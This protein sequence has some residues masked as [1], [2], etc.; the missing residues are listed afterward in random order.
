MKQLLIGVMAL[1]LLAVPL[2]STARDEEND[3]N[4]TELGEVVVT[5]TRTETPLGKVG[6]S[7][8]SVVT[9]EDIEA[10]KQSTV[11][12]VLRAVPGLDV[13]S[14]GGP[15]TQTAISLR[16]A[17]SKNTLILIDGI[18]VNDPS[19][20]NRGANLANITVDNI[21][22]VEVVRGPQ[23]VLYGSNA[24]AG[25]VNI[26]TKK[27]RGKPAVA[28]SIEGGSYGTWKFTADAYGEL[29]EKLNFSLSA[30]R[31]DSDGF[32][33]AN[34]DNPDIPHNGNT[35]EKDGWENTTF[36]GKVGLDITPDADVNLV[37]RKVKSQIDMDEFDFMGGYT[38]DRFVTDPVTWMQVPDPNGLKDGRIDTDESYVKMNVH[39][40]FF[41]RFFESNFYG[42]SSDL[43]REGTDQDGEFSYSYNGKSWEVGWQGGLNFQDINVLS[44]GGAY[45]KEEMASGGYSPLNADARIGS[46]WLQ[47]QLFLWDSL[48]MV[49]GLRY[50]DHSQFGSEPTW[51]IAPSYTFN[52]TGTTLK[53]SYGTGFRAPSLYEL[54][55]E[56]GNPDLEAEK[57]KGWDACVEQDLMKGRLV[58]GAT[59]FNM[60]FTD[61][62][63][64]DPNLSIPGNPFPGGYNQLKGDTDTS[65]V[66]AFVRWSPMTDLTLTGNYTYT[67][68]EDPDGQV[69]EL[70]PKHKVYMNARY[71]LFDKAL[72]N[73]DVY[74]VDERRAYEGSA[75]KYGNTVE[76]LDAYWLVNL[77]ASYDI[78][79]YLQI[80]GR[81]DNLFDEFYEE[82]WSYATPGI[83]G[84]LGFK[85]RFG[86]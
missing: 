17:P 51:R 61:R 53:G 20:T 31:I 46:L 1:I 75:D 32:S 3:G 73:V 10:K 44:F 39:N 56:Y 34:N 81:I 33:I 43:S 86:S 64:W 54:Y 63:D 67:D 78:N 80:Y 74:W 71:R 12:E 41:E 35:S 62:I 8:V 55:S 79:E 22:R 37:F 59:Y 2:Y 5:A 18:M 7:A 83:S 30:G 28:G 21:E 77:S 16:G 38:G 27:G 70:V 11:E 85:V 9:Q 36:S 76:K 24:T 58:V 42:Q 13:R 68:S 69:L 48:S 40:Y 49:A 6:G 82:T 65:G 66:E 47:D 29:K 23:S 52:R 4:V 26:I 19:S 60:T 25:V 50:D 15:G 57:S 84:Y 72:F 14:N 45:F